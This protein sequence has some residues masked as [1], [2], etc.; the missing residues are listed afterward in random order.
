LN[1]PKKSPSIRSIEKLFQCSTGTVLKAYPKLEQD[2]IIYS[3]SKSGY[4]IIDDF[5]NLSTDKENLIDFSAV[6]LSAETFSYKNFQH[7][8]NK[9]IDLYKE[10]LFSYSDPKGLNSLINVLS[11]HIQNYQ[12]FAKPDNIFITSS[13]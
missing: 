5:H 7:C 1:H 10:K 9:S 3:V 13:S 8:L 2:H 11:K 4:Y 6:N 12:I